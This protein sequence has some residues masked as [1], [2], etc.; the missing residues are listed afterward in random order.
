VHRERKGP[1][2]CSW[3]SPFSP[4]LKLPKRFKIAMQQRDWNQR[5]VCYK[6]EAWRSQATAPKIQTVLGVLRAY[7]LQQLTVDEPSAAVRAPPIPRTAHSE[8]SR[9][10]IESTLRR[11]LNLI[12]CCQHLPDYDWQI[13][14]CPTTTVRCLL[15]SNRKFQRCVQVIPKEGDVDRMGD[16]QSEADSYLLSRRIQAFQLL[17]RARIRRWHYVSELLPE[18]AAQK[19]R[20]ATSERATE[21]VV[22]FLGPHGRQPVDSWCSSACAHVSF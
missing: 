3:I 8:L 16:I 18:F 1:A 10:R 22:P 4:I 13:F 11:S 20:R 14:L 21:I 9:D 5:F 19:D 6:L 17:S 12:I 2:I 15:H 7:R